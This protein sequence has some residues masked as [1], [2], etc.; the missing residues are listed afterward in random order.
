[1][2]NSFT[3][4]SASGAS[5]SVQSLDLAS[6]R[7]AVKLALGQ[8]PDSQLISVDTLVN[9][10]LMQ[11]ATL[12]D[13]DWRSSTISLDTVDGQNYINLPADFAGMNDLH[14]VAVWIGA[15]IP[16][17]LDNIQRM[18]ALS[19]VSLGTTYAFYYAISWATQ[20]D[21]G[22]LP[23]ARLELYPAPTSTTTG[24]IIGQ[25][26][27][28]IPKLSNATDVPNIPAT[29]HQALKAWIQL[30]TRRQHGLDEEP[31]KTN[32]E[33]LLAA[34]IDEGAAAQTNLGRLEG[35]GTARRT[36]MIRTYPTIR[37]PT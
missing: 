1:M 23:R 34:A 24:A 20:T 21:A 25:Y 13:W 36:R 10:G 30:Y 6:L 26:T 9:D 8:T 35:V 31:W 12:R 3:S 27:K 32:A 2:S 14:V 33:R 4:S 22:T 28:S 18:R 17:T 11:F 15:M 5:S 16:L 37:L 19:V 7:K 29:M